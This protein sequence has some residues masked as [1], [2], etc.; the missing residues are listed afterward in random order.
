MAERIKEI[1]LKLISEHQNGFT[2]EPKIVDSFILVSEVIHSI[3]KEKQKDMVIK[4]DV[5]KAY[6]WVVWDFLICVLKRFGFPNK[7]IECIKFCISTINFFMIVNGNVCGFFGAT[8]GLRQG[9][10]LSP[11][12]FVVMAEVLWKL[13]Q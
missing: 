12:L 8:N 2:P 6:D 1:L 3:Y 7:W 11:S 5:A 13:I 4:L 10:P 9:D